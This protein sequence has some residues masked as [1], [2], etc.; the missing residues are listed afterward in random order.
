MILNQQKECKIKLS[1]CCVSDV[2]DD[3]D[4]ELDF[5]ED[6]EFD[7]DDELEED[8]DLQVLDFDEDSADMRGGYYPY[9]RSDKQRFDD[10][11]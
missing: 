1:K 9:F 10:E 3:P 11:Y 2:Y 8:D 7:E 5:D 4:D 6:F